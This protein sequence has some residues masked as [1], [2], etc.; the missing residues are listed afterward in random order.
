MSLI[1]YASSQPEKDPSEI[2]VPL[3]APTFP[4]T[5]NEESQCEIA[6]SE[7]YIHFKYGNSILPTSPRFPSIAL[8]SLNPNRVTLSSLTKFPKNV[9]FLKGYQS[10]FNILYNLRTQL[11]SSIQ[12][13]YNSDFDG[14][15]FTLPKTAHNIKSY[16][17]IHDNLAR[18]LFC[19]PNDDGEDENNATREHSYFGKKKVDDE[20]YYVFA[21]KQWE[22]RFRIDDPFLALDVKGP[23]KNS[24]PLNT[25]FAA[26]L[27]S[28]DI[29]TW[30]KLASPA[31][32]A[33]YVFV[34][35]SR[36]IVPKEG[37]FYHYATPSLKFVP[38]TITAAR[39]LRFRLIDIKTLDPFPL[40]PS[41][42]IWI[43]L[44]YRERITSPRNRME[45]DGFE[46]TR[47]MQVYTKDG[48]SPTL[49]IGF[50]SP[51][52]LSPNYDWDIALTSLTF[53]DSYSFDLSLS[54]RT[55]KIP[56]GSPFGPDFKQYEI[57]MP[58]SMELTDLVSMFENQT[59]GAVRGTLSSDG[60]LK[61]F[62]TIDEAQ[63]SFIIRPKAA[64][65][66]GIPLRYLKSNGFLFSGGVYDVPIP[67]GHPWT[68]P[69]KPSLKANRPQAVKVTC[70]DIKPSLVN[71][72]LEP[73]LKMVPI[74]PEDPN[75]ALHV[76]KEWNVL[77]YHKIIPTRL[78][79]ITL[80][81]ID[82]YNQPIKFDPSR[83]EQTVHASLQ[84]RM[85]KK[86]RESVFSS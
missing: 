38:V 75:Q 37:F 40:V 65:I 58:S 32:S 13:N 44:I 21:A 71:G 4:L 67:Q 73:V 42:P 83:L 16:L 66:M 45:R 85:R 17:W 60:R 81:L 27:V 8:S 64:E 28:P 47:T 56:K 51:L 62:Q 50:T 18:Y 80:Q 23:L 52:E 12:M 2:I 74:V 24:V 33:L 72:K 82:T 9:A 39:Q 84:L 14:V 29:Q 59:N 35:P 30:E 77:E 53:P 63:M 26:A 6:L 69:E 68:C 86:S 22:R 25:G 78:K 19:I 1:L 79:S 5:A 76:R 10:Q 41:H 20:T 43:K 3:S 70:P 15:T 57:I 46:K 49:E 34:S 36:F 54:E 7:L 11:L 55:F 61:F 31:Q 48:P